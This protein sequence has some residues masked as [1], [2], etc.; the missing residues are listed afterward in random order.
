MIKAMIPQ[1]PE[2]QCPVRGMSAAPLPEV[3]VGI[4][5]LGARGLTVLRLLLLVPGARVTAL[6][7]SQVSSVA[8]A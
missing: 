4:V 6:C 2:G 1:R 8:A 3:R 5:G 7:C